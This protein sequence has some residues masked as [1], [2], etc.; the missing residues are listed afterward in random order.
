M[1]KETVYIETSIVSYLVARPTRDLITNARQQVTVFWWETKAQDFALYTSTL[2]LDEAKKGDTSAAAK[3]LNALAGL[4]V[5][6]ITAEAIELAELLIK[7]H[8]LP[9][10]AADD[11]LHIAVAA[12]NGIHYLL[13]WNCRHIANAHLRPSIERTC[14][15]AGYEPPTLC[16]P[17]ELGADL[18]TEDS[19]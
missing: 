3:R 1:D 6:P 11:A 4:S 16:T 19:D 17:E 12:L 5:L 8:A 18:V 13:T 7:Q 10:K 9:T 15:T 14:R 2:V